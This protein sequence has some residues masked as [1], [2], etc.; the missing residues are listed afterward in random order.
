MHDRENGKHR[1]LLDKS[2]DTINRVI[3]AFLETEVHTLQGQYP[4]YYEKFR[5]DGVEYDIYIG[6]EIAPDKPF[7]PIYLS[8][9]RLWQLSSMIKIARTADTMA[10]T[11]PTPM[12]VTPLIFVHDHTIDI[13]F[14]ED[15]K[16][17]D[18]EGAYNIRYQ[19]IKKRIDKV[20]IRNSQERLTQPGKL[21]I[22]Y[23]NSRL[24]EEYLPFI[25]Y[26]RKTGSIKNDPEFLELQD[27]QGIEG[28]QAIRLEIEMGRSG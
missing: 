1:E 14:R 11:L 17:F 28:L 12:A 13:T 25:D 16:K 3:S 20:C 23:T 27:L 18:V 8:N 6:Q 21:A 19:M 15:E 10:Q 5:T 26:L 24:L 2:I 9:L 22:I 4:F 7:H